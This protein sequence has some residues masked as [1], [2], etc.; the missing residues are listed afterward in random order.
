MSIVNILPEDS[1]ILAKLNCETDKNSFLLRKTFEYL[2]K[3]PLKFF[4]VIPA[5]LKDFVH[6]FNGRWYPLSMGSKFNLL[7]GL[8]ASLSFLGFWWNR[9]ANID[10]INLSIIFIIGAVISVVIFHGEIRYRFVL[11][12]ILFLLA[13]LCFVNRLSSQKKKIIIAL[14]LLNSIFWGIGIM[15]P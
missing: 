8:L 10:L 15:I 4:T 3:D 5:K 1:A 12:P 7:Y 14:I 11:N 2:M 6:P 9:K 13:G